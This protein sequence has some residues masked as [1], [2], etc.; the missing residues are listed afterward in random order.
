MLTGI[1]A[2]DLKKTATAA[3]A[4]SL[5]YALKRAAERGAFS[6]RWTFEQGSE[7]E[8]TVSALRIRGFSVSHG[9]EADE[10]HTYIIRWGE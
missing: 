10:K 8:A 1:H 7:V 5:A 6:L 3:Q 2:E 4:G 9:Q